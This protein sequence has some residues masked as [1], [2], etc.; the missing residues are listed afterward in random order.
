VHD[1][2]LQVLPILSIVSGSSSGGKCA[3]LDLQMQQLKES[4]LR[5][6]G[7]FTAIG[8][9]RCVARAAARANLWG[10]GYFWFG[11]TTFENNLIQNSICYEFDLHGD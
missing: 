4:R 8:D 11:T 1:Q 7:L 2:G 3:A 5:I 6:I 10:P 9:A